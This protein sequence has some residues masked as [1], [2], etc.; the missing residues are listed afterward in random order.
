VSDARLE[1]TFPAELIEQIAGRAAELALER[2]RA[3]AES[4]S[5]WMTI[6][7]AVA[8]MGG[9]DFERNRQHLYDLRSSGRLGRHGEHGRALVDRHELDAYLGN[10]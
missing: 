6:P 5:R 7:Q 1:L 4:P 3:E 2:L 10:S 9:T 8:Y